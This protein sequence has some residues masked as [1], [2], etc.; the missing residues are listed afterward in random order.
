[1]ARSRV[2]ISRGPPDG[3]A[4]PE[5]PLAP[6]L[7][8]LQEISEEVD[9]RERPPVTWDRLVLKDDQAAEFLKCS[10]QTLRERRIG[11][12]HAPRGGRG[13][14]LL[15]LRSLGLRDR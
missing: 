5:I 7:T 2:P 15:R 8:V 3:Q 11:R 14:A 9:A 1:V 4:R 10:P 13:V 6:D 12:D